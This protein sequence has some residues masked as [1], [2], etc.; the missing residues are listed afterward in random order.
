M[1]LNSTILALLLTV[2]LTTIAYSPVN[3]QDR[4]FI[5]TWQTEFANETITIGTAG[6]DDITDF[7]FRIDWGDGSSENVTGDDPDPTHVYSSAGTYTVSITGTFPWM[8]SLSVDGMSK[9]RS[10][11]QWG[12]IEWESMSYTFLKADSMQ[13]NTTEAPNLTAVTDMSRMFRGAKSFNGD[14]SNWDVSLVTNMS[15]MFILADLFSGELSSWDVSSV[16][17]MS[18]MFTLASSFNGNLSSWD[19]SSVTNMN[20]MFY[21]AG[22]FNG[23]LS[24]WDVSL[25]TDMSYMFLYAGSFNGDLSNWDMSSVTDING[26]FYGATVFNG[27]ISN[28]DVSSATEMLRMFKDATSFNGDLSQ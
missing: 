27:D 14:L 15:G 20:R 8:N 26:M 12:D 16:T 11:E 10:I 24:T 17:D 18:N 5:T 1:R 25:V 21:Q 2:F 6:G 7:D 28:W 3:A 23:D 13:L 22:S 19:V 4:P 9:L